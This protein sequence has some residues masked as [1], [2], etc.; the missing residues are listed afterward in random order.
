MENGLELLMVAGTMFV[1]GFFIT[2]TF[3]QG[4]AIP[5]QTQAKPLAA[6]PAAQGLGQPQGLA[7]ELSLDGYVQIKF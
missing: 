5:A 4:F 6:K 1:L 2:G 3:I 7:E